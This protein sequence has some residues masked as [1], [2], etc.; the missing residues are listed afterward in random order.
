MFSVFDEGPL[1]DLK[2]YSNRLDGFECRLD[3][4][5]PSV[6]LLSIN[7]LHLPKALALCHVC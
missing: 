1:T 6:P 4:I 2:D 7:I 5:H 3:H